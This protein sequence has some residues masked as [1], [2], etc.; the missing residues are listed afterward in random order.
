[1]LNAL[2]VPHV[3]QPR[4][5]APLFFSAMDYIGMGL[6]R[7]GISSGLAVCLEELDQK[8]CFY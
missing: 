3:P 2:N 4:F 6:N 7:D 8:N 1:M 5:I